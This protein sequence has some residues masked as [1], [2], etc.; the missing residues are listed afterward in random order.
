MYNGNFYQKK[1]RVKIQ[2]QLLLTAYDNKVTAAVCP[3][4][5]YQG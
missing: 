4:N 3:E 1:K 2:T 5:V